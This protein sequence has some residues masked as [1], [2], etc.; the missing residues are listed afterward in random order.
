MEEVYK[1]KTLVRERERFTQKSPDYYQAI[2]SLTFHPKKLTYTFGEPDVRKGEIWW[3]KL[4]GL[5]PIIPVRAKT[6]LY[7]YRGRYHD[8][9]RRYTTK[10]WYFNWYYG[11]G[12]MLDG[13]K[14]YQKAIVEIDLDNYCGKN[15]EA[16]TFTDDNT[17]I[18]YF[19]HIEKMCKK[20]GNNLKNKYENS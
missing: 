12:Y 10:D 16:E 4:L 14:V 19:D 13:D 7:K 18:A 15:Y 6:D 2:K 5:I 8:E 9:I 1:K 11:S 20:F 3:W 17:A